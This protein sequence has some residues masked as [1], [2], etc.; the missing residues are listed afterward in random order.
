MK[1]EMRGFAPLSRE[2]DVVAGAQAAVWELALLSFEEITKGLPPP[3]SQAAPAASAAP[4]GNNTIRAQGGRGTVTAAPPGQGFQRAGVTAPARP[5]AA[6]PAGAP[7]AAEQ[8]P[9]DANAA[10]DG[11][12]VNGSVNNG[13]ASPF[14]QF[15]AFGNNRRRPGALYNAQFGVT[16]SSSAWDAKSY[17][18]TGQQTAVPDYHNLQFVGMFQG[19]LRI[20]RLLPNRGPNLFLGYQRSTDDRATTASQRM[21]TGLERNGDFSQTVDG[22]GRPITVTDPL[23]GQPFANNTIPRDRISPEAAALLGYY[24]RPTLAS[25]VGYNYQ[26]PILSAIRTDSFQSRVTQVV[27]QRNQIFGTGSYLRSTVE[28]DLAVRLCRSDADREYRRRGELEPPRLAVPADAN[29]L[30]VHETVHNRHA[31]LC[32]PRQRVWRGRN[33][34]QQPGSHQL[35]ATVVILLERRRTLGRTA[36]TIRRDDPHRRRRGLPLPRTAQLHH[37]RRRPSSSDRHSVAA[38][39]ARLVRVH[40]RRDRARFRRLPPRH[41]DDGGDC[42]RQRRQILPR[43][44]V[45]RVHHRRLAHRTVLHG[46]GRCALGIRG[47]ADRVA[48]A[49]GES[50]RRLRLHGSAAGAVIEPD[51]RGD[52]RDVCELADAAGQGWHSASAGPRLASDSRLVARGARRATASIEIPTCISRSRRCSR[53]SRRSRR[54]SASPTARRIR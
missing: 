50:R 15:A 18:L 54:R 2:V 7:P 17:S 35:G 49:P 5:A 6:A 43:L 44:L 24:P 40:R 32:Q 42:V 41:A 39:P 9:A 25:N 31:V 4:A 22:L 13:A 16:A 37:R 46:D 51:R 14:A 38:E 48:V 47:A 33:H 45:R 52:G 11:F 34:R 23:T 20:P 3:V 26:A 12:L 19:P 21:P 30:P 53:S 1:I 29:S 8:P 10:N 27:N 36:T 28:C